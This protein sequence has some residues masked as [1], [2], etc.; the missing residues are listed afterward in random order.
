M[1]ESTAKNGPLSRLSAVVG[2]LGVVATSATACWT[3]FH[4]DSTDIADYQSQVV[5]TCEQV[6][7]V[8]TEDHSEVVYLGGGKNSTLGDPRDMVQIRRDGMIHVL[9]SAGTRARIGF[10]ALNRRAIPETLTA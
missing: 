2:I 7:K 5:A 8:F 9:Q 6:H 4:R 3:I 1:G 10:D